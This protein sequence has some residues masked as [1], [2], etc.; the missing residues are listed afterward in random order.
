MRGENEETEVKEQGNKENVADGTIIWDFVN[1][2][3]GATGTENTFTITE[4]LKNTIE[5]AG[6]TVDATNGKIKDNGNSVA[7]NGGTI[8]KI[9]LSGKSKIT[10][11]A[12]GTQYALYTLNNVAASTSNVTSEFICSGEY[13]ELKATQNTAY[14]NSITVEP[15]Q[16]V[17]VSGSVK[18]DPAIEGDYQVIFTDKEDGTIVKATVTNGTYEGALCDGTYTISLSND[19]YNIT[20]PANKEITVAGA[21][22]IDFMIEAS[23]MDL[24]TVTGNITVPA[25]TNLSGWKLSFTE[26]VAENPHT[27]ETGITTKE[28]GT[29]S[30]SAD[31]KKDTSYKVTVS[32]THSN[33]YNISP[34]TI[35]KNSADITFTAKTARDVTVNITSYDGDFDA[36]AAEITFTDIDDEKCIHTFTGVDNIALRDGE[37]SVDVALTGLYK[38]ESYDNFT[39]SETSTSYNINLVER[40]DWDFTKRSDDPALTDIAYDPSTDEDKA[41]VV[42]Y[43]GL[44]I[45]GGKFA[46]RDSDVQVNAGAVIKIPV[47]GTGKVQIVTYKDTYGY[48]M[49]AG[50]SG[51]EVAAT[52]PQQSWNYTEDTDYMIM[53]VKTQLYLN[54]IHITRDP[55]QDDTEYRYEWDFTNNDNGEWTDIAI[56]NDMGT[57]PGNIKVD[58]RNSGKFAYRTSGDVQVNSPV[59]II[60]PVEGDSKITIEMDNLSEANTYVVG[61]KRTAATSKTQTFTVKGDDITTGTTGDKYITITVTAGSIYL[62]KI[63]VE[64]IE[65]EIVNPSSS[66]PGKNTNGLSDVWDFAG[67]ATAVDKDGNPTAYID[68]TKYNNMLTEDVINSWFS[69]AEPGSSGVNT[70]SFE[71]KNTE[72]K[73]LFEFNGGGKSNHRIRTKNT[74]VT[75][76]DLNSKK[77]EDGNEYLGF[78]YSNASGK[79]L[80]D[81]STVYLGIMLEAGDAVTAMVGSN[82]GASTI[83]FEPADGSGDAQT[84]EY[85]VTEGVGVKAAKFYATKTGEYKIYTTNEKLVVARVTVEKRDYVKV[86]GTVKAPASLTK[87]YSVAFRCNETGA[88]KTAKVT[89]GK[90]AIYLNEGYTY[91][92][93]LDNANGYIVDD[94]DPNFTLEGE[95]KEGEE[96]KSFTYDVNVEA[97]DLV[98][99]TGSVKGFEAVAGGEQKPLS[100]LKLNFESDNIYVPEFKLNRLDGTFT[101]SL[102]KGVTYK[103]AAEKV[104]DFSLDTA[105]ISASEDGTAD[106]IFTKKP[107]YNVTITPQGVTKETL[108]STSFIFSKVGIE[109]DVK[110]YDK[111]YVY[112]FIGTEGIQLRDGQYE[113]SVGAD[114]PYTMKTTSDLKVNG[115]DAEKVIKFDPTPKTS[116]DFTAAAYTGQTSFGGLTITGGKKH[117]T[118]YGMSIGGSNASVEIPVPG[119]CKIV[120]SVGYNWDVSLDGTEQNFK[121]NTNS[122]DIDVTFDYTGEAGTARLTAGSEFTSYIKKIEVRAEA[123]KTEYKEKITVGATG[124]DYT[125]INDALD[126][127]RA[128]NRP[129]NERVTIEIQPGDYEEMLVV[130]TPNVTLKNANS[131]P[132]IMPI[133]KGVNIEASSVRI[134]SYYGHGYAYYSMGEDCKWNADILEANKENGCMSFENPGTGT[135]S[136]SYWNATVVI[137]ADGFEADGIIFENSFNQ[138]V[139]KKAADDVIVPLSGAKEGSTPRAS[140]QAGVT[141]VQDKKYVERAAALA[142]MNGYKQ[143]NFNH[144]SFISRQDTLYGGTDVTAAFYDCDVYGGTDYIFGGMTAVFAKCDLIFNTMEDNNDVGHIT[145]AQTAKDTRGYLMY[146]CHV[147]S[148]IPGKNTASEKTS[149]PGTFGRPWSADTA[150]AVFFYTVIDEVDAYWQEYYNNL[151][152][153]DKN[154][155]YRGKS[156]IAPVGW[157]SGLSGESKRSQEYGTY[158][159]AEGTDNSANRASWA[160]VLTE[161]KL[162]DGQKI[163]VAKFL[164]S[165]NPFAGKDMTIEV[166][167][168]KIDEPID[169]PDNPD[170]PSNKVAAPTSSVPEGEVPAGTE[171]ILTSTT[172][173]AAIYYTT[174]GTEPNAENGIPYTTPIV[175][176]KNM[177]ITAIA[178]KG[179]SA[180]EVRTFVYT[181]ASE[182]VV[183]TTIN[184]NDCKIAVSSIL[185]DKKKNPD[186]M[187]KTSV[188]YEVKDEQGKI[189]DQIRFAQGLDYEIVD[190][191]VNKAGTKEWSVT[192]KGKGR[193]VDAYRL[194]PESTV[195]KT[196]KVFD[197]KADKDIIIDLSKAKI[198]LDGTEK[199]AIYTG[200]SQ[201]PAVTKVMVGKVEITPDKYKVS[202][203][204]NTNAGKASVIISADSDVV[205]GETEKFVIGTKTVNFTI[206]KAAINK[207][208]QITVTAKDADGKDL[209]GGEYDYKG[210]DAVEARELSV[211]TSGGRTLRRNID[212]TATYKN[213]RK[214]GKASLTIKGIGNNVSGSLTIPFTIK[215]LNIGIDSEYKIATT[216]DS[217]IYS[218]NGAKI[219]FICAYK[220]SGERIYLE[221]GVDFKVK[222]TY[223]DKK[224]KL[225]DSEVDFVGQGMN[226]CKGYFSNITKGDNGEEIRTIFKIQK[227]C[228]RDSIYLNDDV[229]VDASKTTT[230]DKLQKAVEKA[231]VATD[232]Y[233]AKLKNKKDYT[234]E[235]NESEKRVIIR[236][237]DPTCYLESD[238][239][240]IFGKDYY[241]WTEYTQA[242]NIK[243]VKPDKK[244]TVSYD[245]RN[246]VELDKDD[247]SKLLGGLKLNED[248]EIVEGSYKNN[249]KAGSASVTIRG[250]GNYYGTTTIKFKIIEA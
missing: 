249:Y 24:E 88:V 248:V 149:K 87:A 155:I 66:V 148:T 76:F 81:A 99:V 146:N 183:V 247:I 33:D 62:Y 143:M 219:G 233:G 29:A 104:D 126:A 8:I 19:K 184:I 141:T 194:D 123:G 54:E 212:Y 64:P 223:K 67:G 103:L 84:Y 13:A 224:N 21:A 210:M 156:L 25:N 82:G 39:V 79:E 83:K 52:N 213:N 234:V 65:E 45:N 203:K 28:D 166:G 11:I 225:P 128:M 78:V 113:I 244:Y 245:G 177:T 118:Q 211:V 147:T 115:G 241:V 131:D 98:T 132:S 139:S 59:G 202:Y 30:Y 14:I 5:I 152:D 17:K 102:E 161:P 160:T 90:Y 164:G 58:A 144:C 92:V 51:E 120:V 9:P 3:Y 77:G 117:G 42:K 167:D 154:A 55:K 142:I 137:G 43:N 214:A 23:A 37:Y 222:Y 238:Y 170:D 47:S 94:A 46:T 61:E 228:F 207:A 32:G 250:I 57:I 206:K 158:E 173:G 171:V 204:S 188:V 179:E 44:E 157:D 68:T 80:E 15:F 56:Q 63:K 36:S 74:K 240:D 201:R 189:V 237:K 169:D 186:N 209:K 227:A 116:W 187:P 216:E 119:A 105:T 239:P 31:L 35:N 122:G 106:I 176:D 26:D 215:P 175:I 232:Y 49:M 185:E 162:L 180:S 70:S 121:D 150:E 22:I 101:L 199:G 151:D 172:E 130:D 34:S 75:R 97:V 218:P 140:M 182:P 16:T 220:D 18:V 145:A 229:I 89:N 205:Y 192:L 133:D 86:S 12:F 96:E 174:D 108:A 125:S 196:F 197:K 73:V 40:M 71:V 20:T 246:P 242:T 10:I 110:V 91:N 41:T 230:A 153:S 236:P 200:Y 72:D 4:T 134:T 136:G 217:L 50:S 168:T 195:T 111:D 129:D 114:C 6:L 127:V 53:Q 198:T 107:V 193:A 38:R 48:S 178:I 27:V 231:V 7:L 138:Y 69:S 181:V 191:P 243:T 235:V 221:E 190:K 85:T 159:K 165:W 135:T 112:T 124:C 208:D 109:N 226:A 1:K 95:I 163:T 93:A 2:K 100:K 60:V